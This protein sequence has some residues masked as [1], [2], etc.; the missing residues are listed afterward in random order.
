MRDGRSDNY[1]GVRVI[2]PCP[3]KIVVVSLL[4]KGHY[5]TT[6]ISLVDGTVISFSKKM[7]LHSSISLQ[8]QFS[9]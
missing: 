3:Y 9:L 6:N 5:E 7:S 4:L 8:Q 2:H 1:Y